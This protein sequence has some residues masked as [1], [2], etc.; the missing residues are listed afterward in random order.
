M[1]LYPHLGSP[2]QC[3][4]GEEVAVSPEPICTLRERL[5]QCLA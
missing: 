4:R 5:P 3:A 2:E 1:T